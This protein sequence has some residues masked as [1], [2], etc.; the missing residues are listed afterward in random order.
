[1]EEHQGEIREK[2][3]TLFFSRYDGEAW[4]ENLD[5]LRRL[6]YLDDLGDRGDNESDCFVF[7]P[8]PESWGRKSREGSIFRKNDPS[9]LTPAP[10]PTNSRPR[11]HLMTSLPDSNHL[12]STVN[13]PFWLHVV[14]YVLPKSRHQRPRTQ[15]RWLHHFTCQYTR[16][17]QC[18]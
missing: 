12:R 14:R 2:L 8:H 11:T 18:Y 3:R 5:F 13:S 15:R 6:E 7:G 4:G 17:D 16:G 10:P 1:M 9:L